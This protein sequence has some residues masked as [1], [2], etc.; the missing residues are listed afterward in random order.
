MKRWLNL[1]FFVALFAGVFFYR[2]AAN[3]PQP[4]KPLFSDPLPADAEHPGNPVSMR[5]GRAALEVDGDAADPIQDI[6]LFRVGEKGEKGTPDE[7]VEFTGGWSSA[8]HALWF[9]D[10]DPKAT[11]RAEVKTQFRKES[12]ELRREK[13]EPI[14]VQRVRVRVNLAAEH[15]VIAEFS[16]DN[17]WL[18]VA[19]SAGDLKLVSIDGQE[20]R[21]NTRVQHPFVQLDFYGDARARLEGQG[22]NLKIRVEQR[23]GGMVLFGHTSNPHDR[24][25]YDV[26]TGKVIPKEERLVW[27]SAGRRPGPEEEV[28]SGPR[29]SNSLTNQNWM[30]ID[31]SPT[32]V[33]ELRDHKKVPLYSIP[34]PFAAVSKELR[35]IAVIEEKK[36]PNDQ[37]EMDIDVIV[38]H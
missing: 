11:Y 37:D 18:A 5:L 24:I 28:V 35:F 29:P 30:I 25:A 7:K 9:F 8:V 22:D 21:I 13:V 32:R 34:H 31:A 2:R 1:I 15:L 3:H 6:K 19:S 4:S 36:P 20:T 10:L 17:K 16:W 12:R 26:S 27:P 33:L 14:E 38:Y 23:A